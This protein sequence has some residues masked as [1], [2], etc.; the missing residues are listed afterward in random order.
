[1][2]RPVEPGERLPQESPIQL[3]NLALVDPKEGG[4]TRVGFRIEDGKKVEKDAKKAVDDIELPKLELD[5]LTDRK[6][7]EEHQGEVQGEVRDTM[8]R[9]QRLQRDAKEK[10][11]ELDRTVIGVG[12]KGS[13]SK[14][15]PPACDE[16]LFYDNLVGSTPVRGTSGAS[17][18][19]SDDAPITS[20]SSDTGIVLST[21]AGLEGSSGS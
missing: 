10:L 18:D 7:L 15:L 17:D 16:F 1:M 8:R 9:V 13:T 2:A 5:S 3:S 19:D 4:P 20:G 12:V 11:R 21:L 6:K 14:L